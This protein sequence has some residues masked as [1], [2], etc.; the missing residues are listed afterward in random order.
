MTHAGRVGSHVIGVPVILARSDVLARH[1]PDIWS[2]PV[3]SA[4]ADAAREGRLAEATILHEVR[5]FHD[6][7]LC[8]PLY[9]R[10][11]VAVERNAVA[12][13]LL[14]DKMREG[15]GPLGPGALDNRQRALIE[16]HRETVKDVGHRH[17]AAYRPVFVEEIGAAVT[18][19]DMLEANAMVTELCFLDSTPDGQAYDHWLSLTSV[20][21]EKYT[22]IINWFVRSRESFSEDLDRVGNVLM[23]CLYRQDASPKALADVI[24]L[25]DT[26]I[27]ALCDVREIP[28]RLETAR[29]ARQFALFQLQDTER[30]RRYFTSV[31]DIIDV[32]TRCLT[33]MSD[34]AFRTPAYVHEVACFPMPATGFFADEAMI[35]NRTLPFVRKADIRSAYGDVFSMSSSKDQERRTA[36]ACGL[37]PTLGIAPCLELNRVHLTLA[38]RFITQGLFEEKV[39]YNFS[40]DQAFAELSREWIA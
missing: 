35:K 27:D 6:S 30:A 29:R 26:R 8:P 39:S 28:Q 32:H 25:A 10:F 9:D 1:R 34:I 2:A 12:A 7:L 5:H 4:A 14:G 3:P 36:V 24:G 16:L 33:R 17:E 19:T 37:F 15:L 18:L 11:M 40:M 21:P 31:Q 20:L 38:L 22:K 13:T 23:W